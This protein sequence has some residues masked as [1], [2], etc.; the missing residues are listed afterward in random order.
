[1]RRLVGLAALLA[2]AVWLRRRLGGP[3][4]PQEQVTVGYADGSAS[5]LD[6][7]SPERELL[8]AT[9]ADAL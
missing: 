7:G 4:A 2:L 1:M 3:E 5:M 8:L 6:V 9:A